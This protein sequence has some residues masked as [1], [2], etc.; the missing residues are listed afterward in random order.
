LA[1][2]ALT[3][4][5]AAAAFAFA[6]ETPPPPA[7][8][9][10]PAESS[11]LPVENPP[12]AP[13]VGAIEGFV[14][15]RGVRD[16]VAGATVRLADAD[17]KTV[18]DEEGKFRFDAVPAGNYTLTVEEESIQKLS[19]PVRVKAGKTATAKCYVN[20]VGYSL[21]EVVVTSKK[22]PEETTR[23]EIS[24]QEL[25]GVP[26]AN[27]DVIR[28]VQSLP[29]VAATGPGGFGDPSGLVIRGTSPTDS[30]YLFNDFPIPQ[31]F[32]F[33]EAV[34]TINSE[35]IKDIVYYPGGF[36]VKYG[37][38]IGGVVDVISRDPRTD[39]FGG[40]VDLATYSSYLMFE[41][42]AG[43]QC[44]WAGSVRRS[45]ID[46]LLP[47][48]VPKDQAE[49]TLAPAFYDYSAIFEYNPNANNHVRATFAGSDDRLALIGQTSANQPFAGNSFD[50]LTDW[51]QGNVRWDATP[52]AS[53]AN[54]LAVNFLYY[55]T[56]DKFGG[57]MR[58]EVSELTPSMRDDF[59]V[60]VGSWN[61]LRWGLEAEATSVALNLNVIRPPSEGHPGVS[62]SNGDLAVEKYGIDAY[63]GA[64]YLDDVMKPASWVQITPGV[65]TDYSEYLAR[66]TADP[67][68][69]TK[70]FPSKEATIKAT[71]GVYHEWPQADEIVKGIG[72]PHLDAE[73]AY[74]TLLGC[75]YDF[76]QGWSLDAEGYYNRLASIP[77]ATNPGDAVPYRNTG[78]GYIYGAELLAR[79]KLTDR[80]FGWVSYTYTVSERKDTPSSP[81]RYFDNDQRHNF[82]ILANYTLGEKK[83]WRIGGKWQFFTNTPYTPIVGSVYNADTDSYL[84][85]YSSRI[86]SVRDKPYHQLDVR[87]DKLWI[88]NS[89]TL[90]T[91]LDVQN[92]Y[93]NQY[94]VGYVYNYDY[95]QKKPV[96]LAPFFPSIGI[97]ARF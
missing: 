16:P 26:G 71:A 48:V 61:E 62:I 49:F 27:N 92:V 28:V 25:T 19:L 21:D 15:V 91:Y 87:V 64:L 51:H 50:T 66:A 63:G 40:V 24:K 72:N 30:A 97:D 54:T 86:N 6:D 2:L 10:A 45:F 55:D 67:R 68:L 33:G 43:P 29:G 32:H 17:R 41:G 85:I 9:P 93:W 75:E 59:S 38:A 22:E 74:Q 11:P 57:G 31:L 58:V 88:F 77:T 89:W 52:T 96:S 20:R 46:F 36:G 81:W 65:R 5:L 1:F 60:K 3:L 78:I 69:L 34:S 4:L 47:L 70:F 23:Q 39:R 42:P 12:P 13:E 95:T 82:I 18:T 37:Q 35:L 76:G 73:V 90:S 14:H 44:S 7:D 84:P 8:A 94:P 56:L 80:L 53:I 79:K 83:D